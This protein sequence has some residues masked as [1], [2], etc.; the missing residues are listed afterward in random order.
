M[1][2]TNGHPLA[3]AIDTIREYDRITGTTQIARRYLAMNAFDGVL[4]IIGVLAGSYVAGVRSASVV[5]RT[6]IATSIAMA[7]SGLWGAYLTEAAERRRELSEL[8]R[9]TLSDLQETKIARASRLAVLIAALVD[10]LAPLVAAL[11]VLVPLLV[12][13]LFGD[14][15]ISYAA[16]LTVGLIGLF[17]LGVFLG[18]IS[19]RNLIGYGL[20]TLVAGLV[21]LA[22]S[23]LLGV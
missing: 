3:R 22:L 7:V 11:L 16:S 8:E 4:T 18:H 13:P 12:A 15:R 9:L 21:S 5:V 14:I 17:G 20:R 1:G 2:D 19:R 10:G 23:L 6:G